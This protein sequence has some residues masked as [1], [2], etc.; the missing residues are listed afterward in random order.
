MLLGLVHA[1]KVAKSFKISEKDF[2]ILFR[3]FES[4]KNS[5]KYFENNWIFFEHDL[6]V[7]LTFRKIIEII[8]FV[9]SKI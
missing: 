7:T 5:E 3:F 4:L 1:G 8:F 6:S 2:E 9:F